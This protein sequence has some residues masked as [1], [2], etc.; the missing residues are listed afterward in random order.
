M[1]EELQSFDRIQNAVLALHLL[2]RA[3][4]ACAYLGIPKTRSIFIAAFLF[5]NFLL[6]AFLFCLII[7]IVIFLNIIVSDI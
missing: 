3:F 6:M 2:G 5:F 7:F 4:L 1:T